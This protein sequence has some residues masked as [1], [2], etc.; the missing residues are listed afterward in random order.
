MTGNFERDEHGKVMLVEPETVDQ[1]CALCG[2]P[3]AVRFG[4]FGKFLGCTGYPECKGVA[5]LFKPQPTGIACPQCGGAGELLERR[6]R[7]GSAFWSCSRYPDCQYAL[8]DQPV[9]EPCPRCGAPLVT[10]KATK[11]WGTVRR[12]VQ[13]G[14][15]WQA[16]VLEDGSLEE[17]PAALAASSR[18]RG[19]R[20]AAAGETPA[21]AASR[22]AKTRKPRQASAEAKP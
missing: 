3:M 10:E 12:C 11:R 21:A 5:P 4:R 7:R 16:Q 22:R 18:R 15:G 17:L 1:T 6:S 8:W 2:K 19:G 14:C 13:E 20:A 9:A